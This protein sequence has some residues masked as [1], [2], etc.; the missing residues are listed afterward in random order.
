MSDILEGFSE[1]VAEDFFSVGRLTRADG[2]TLRISL[3]K[4]AVL[5]E[6]LIEDNTYDELMHRERFLV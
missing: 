2:Q 3:R 4:T 5:T 6:I 1:D